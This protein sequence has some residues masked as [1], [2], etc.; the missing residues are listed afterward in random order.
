MTRLAQKLQVFGIGFSKLTSQLLLAIKPEAIT[1]LQ[2]EILHFLYSEKSVTLGQIAACTGM[3]L[4]NTS[5]EVRKL[6]EKSLVAKRAALEDKRV[7][8]VELTPE[9]QELMMLSDSRLEQVVA[10]KYANLTPDEAGQVTAALELLSDKLLKMNEG[11]PGQ[12]S[13]SGKE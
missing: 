10:D 9:G 6:V 2:F 12:A 5:R 4:P 7:Y 3:S 1:L 13:H 11:P 8:Y